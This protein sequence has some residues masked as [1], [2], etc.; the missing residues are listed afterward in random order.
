MTTHYYGCSSPA[1]TFKVNN[2]RWLRVNY[3]LGA[4]FLVTGA[5]YYHQDDSAAVNLNLTLWYR[6][7]PN[8]VPFYSYPVSTLL[9]E[10]VTSKCF[11]G[12]YIVSEHPAVVLASPDTNPSIAIGG[13]SPNSGHSFNSTD[14]FAWTLSPSHEYM[15]DLLY[16]PFWDLAPG[17]PSYNGVIDTSDL[18]D[19]Y[20]V[21]LL[22]G[23]TYDFKM[24]RKSGSGDLKMYV[25]NYTVEGT[26]G[27]SSLNSTFM[28]T[29]DQ[30]VHMRYTP[31]ITANYMLI[32]EP[33]VYGDSATYDVEYHDLNAIPPIPTLLSVTPDASTKTFTITWSSSAGADSY[34]VYFSTQSFT[35]L[36]DY[37]VTVV[38]TFTTTTGQNVVVFDGDY[39][40]AVTAIN[41]T[42]GESGISNVMKGTMETPYTP[43]SGIAGFPVYIVLLTIFIPAVL[44]LRRA[45][46]KISRL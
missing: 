20:N 45:R 18:V 14:G 36:S 3:T 2:T 5:R 42:G 12:P 22:A 31:S 8:M 7:G 28:F 27:L 6:T 17:V 38:N 15:V 24:T 30:S 33:N 41:I 32:V 44:L 26:T 43:P 21:S 19:G 34:R 9:G 35:S 29:S 4:V 37:G 10:W 46:Q 23:H 39:Y 11:R 40:Y 13:C 1:A 16:E 25:V